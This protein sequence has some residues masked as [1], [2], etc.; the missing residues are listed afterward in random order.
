[1]LADKEN[2]QVENGLTGRVWS[3]TK[4]TYGANPIRAS[5][6]VAGKARKVPPAIQV[7]GRPVE[8]V[9]SPLRQQFMSPL[10]E[11]S[12]RTATVANSSLTQ[13]F[14]QSMSLDESVDM[15]TIED[16][17]APGFLSPGGM[18]S[19]MIFGTKDGVVWSPSRQ[20]Q[21]AAARMHT[22]K[23]DLM[24]LPASRKSEASPT[25]V[26]SPSP[27]DPFS[28]FPSFAAV[29]SLDHGTERLIIAYPP[30]AVTVAFA[31][32]KRR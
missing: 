4:T 11:S 30:P 18:V 13:A 1:V 2:S 26:M 32:G 5:R 14:W 6:E 10:N 21:N 12:Q 29:L 20:N 19:P 7:I 23:K 16:P 17:V 15:G 31:D 27:E 22:L 9:S 25:M 28:A 24:A 3:R 8:M